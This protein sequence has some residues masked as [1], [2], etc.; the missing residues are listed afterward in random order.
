MFNVKAKT[1][2]VS[3]A[4]QIYIIATGY[5]DWNLQFFPCKYLNDDN[6]QGVA[7]TFFQFSVLKYP[8]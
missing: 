3:Y 8:F 2:V 6:K 1:N 5:S 4:Y 7:V